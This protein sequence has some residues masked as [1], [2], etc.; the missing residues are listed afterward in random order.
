MTLATKCRIFERRMKLCRKCGKPGEFSK[1][2]KKPD[3]LQDRCKACF[4]AYH[5]EKYEKNKERLKA[6]MK[7]YR[8]NNRE[9]ILQRERLRSSRP[10]V[11]SRKRSL[12]RLSYSGWTEEMFKQAW[13]AQ[14]G[15]CAICTTT[16]TIGGTTST[17][18]SADH[19][20]ATGRQRSLLC[21][22]CNSGLG[23]FRDAPELLEAA[24]DYLRRHLKTTPAG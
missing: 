5:R 2:S 17:S 16:M 15:R 8:L 24:A 3:G 13:D 4:S 19:C 9:K 21:C 7:A 12:A 22:S 20:H 6:G 1:N 10:D 18:V 11:R 14:E 23:K